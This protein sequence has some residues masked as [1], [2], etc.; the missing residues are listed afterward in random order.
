MKN[1]ASDYSSVSNLTKKREELQFTL[2]KFLLLN[3]LIFTKVTGLKSSSKNIKC[4]L[5]VLIE[6]YS[7]LKDKHILDFAK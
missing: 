3:M 7:F 6:K 5:Q 1:I 2:I 4:L